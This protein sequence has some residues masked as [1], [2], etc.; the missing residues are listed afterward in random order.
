VKQAAASLVL[1]ATVAA[2]PAPSS[3]DRDAYATGQAYV[4]LFQDSV[5]PGTCGIVL[6]RP[7][8]NADFVRVRA[9]RGDDSNDAA[10]VAWLAEGD[11]ALAIA[12][13][14]GSSISDQAW[15]TL[16]AFAW[17]YTAGAI[18]IAID[19][20]RI[21]ATSDYLG[22]YVSA[23][24]AHNGAAP[25]GFKDLLSATG[26]PFERAAPLQRAIDAAIPNEPYPLPRL[27]SGGAVALG[28]YVA[29]LL[30]LVDNPLALSRPESRA[31]ATIVLTELQRRHKEYSD[32]LSVASL[33]ATVNGDMPTTPQQVDTNWRQPLQ[34]N[35]VNT[36]WP[37]ATR[38]ALVIG[39][40]AAQVAY[41]AA[42]L[43][44]AAADAQFRRALAALSPWP[45]MTQSMR[46]DVAKLQRVP[47]QT[48]GGSWSDINRA[49]TRLTLD[50]VPSQ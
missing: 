32:G 50:L 33:L 1:I 45:E 48:K 29:T 9:W 36:K 16:P 39:M 2:A 4:R 37:E 21:D 35:I 27:Q 38:K 30:E 46:T 43:K 14:N 3:A 26:S 41:N 11:V 12:K 23:I 18:S 10:T 6:Q 20:P 49:A 42:A 47:P 19:Q 31:F 15:Q 5:M 40:C 22:Y 7:R 44:D 25:D 34:Q 17:W 8:C 24:A 13:W 28:V